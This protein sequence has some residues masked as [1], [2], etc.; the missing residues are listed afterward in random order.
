MQ[1]KS[2]I[3]CDEQD[4]IAVRNSGRKIAIELGFGTVDQSRILTVVSEMARNIYKYAGKGS[5]TLQPL[6]DGTK[7]GLRIIADD[8]G[9]GIADI[10][11]AMEQGFSTSG[12]LGAGLPAIKRMMDEFYISSEK[13]Q[14]TYIKAIKWIR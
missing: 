2:I 4:I 1:A 3:I 12:S 10:D 11:K 7:K 14:G 6:A 8:N 5:I 9:Q 13:G